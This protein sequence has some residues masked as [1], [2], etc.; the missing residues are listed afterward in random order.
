V[1]PISI[2]PWPSS[3]FPLKLHLHV[4]GFQIILERRLVHATKAECSICTF[5]YEP[6]N[7][8]NC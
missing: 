7:R 1:R 3:S 8:Y 5:K 4:H 2:P 6:I